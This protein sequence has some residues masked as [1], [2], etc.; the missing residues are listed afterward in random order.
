MMLEIQMASELPGG[1]F[2]TQ[3]AGL[4]PRFWHHLSGVGP[5]IYVSN[6][7]PVDTPGLGSLWETLTAPGDLEAP[8]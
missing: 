3:I 1:F 7:F 5:R 6:M 4:Q 8:S 2:K